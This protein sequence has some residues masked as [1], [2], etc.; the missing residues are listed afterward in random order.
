MSPR[1]LPQVATLTTG[2]YA[3]HRLL[4]SPQV[5]TLTTG[6]YAHHRL[7]RSQQVRDI[8]RQRLQLHAIVLAD[9]LHEVNLLR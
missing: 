5:A 1:A 4:R 3:H 7:L 6:C 2:C 9:I 8:R